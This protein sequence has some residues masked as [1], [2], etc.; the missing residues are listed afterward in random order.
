MKGQQ[1]FYLFF[2][3]IFYSFIA[4]AGLIWL[5]YSSK[6]G[7]K[8]LINLHNPASIC[9]IGIG[10]GILVALISIFM[11]KIWKF[12]Q[13]IEQ[14]F[15]N[16]LGHQSVLQIVLLAAM[17]SVAEEIFFR[18][19]MQQSI[20]LVFTSIIFA[21]VHPPVNEKL[22]FWPFFAFAVGILLGY[23]MQETRTL[24]T[25]IL[26]HFTINL[27]NLLRISAKYKLLVVQ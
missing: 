9:V 21:F 10:S 12:A 17:S 20:G 22:L 3:V 19:A 15:G 14:E 26:T 13:E 24:L 6:V 27:I 5:Q 16:L 4:L 1:K 25:P 7:I 18:G 8:P 11:V 2:G 23:Q